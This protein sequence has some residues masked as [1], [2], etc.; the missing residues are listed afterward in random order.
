MEVEAV[1]WWGT[2]ARTAPGRGRLAGR[3]K[4][5]F[6]VASM[7]HGWSWLAGAPGLVLDRSWLGF[8]LQVCNCIALHAI[9]EAFIGD[10]RH[11]WAAGSIDL[12]C[13][14]G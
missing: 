7:A 14:D 9:V 10:L 2:P 13:T 12:Y 6:D 4:F 1:V 11:A 8:P 3:S 5:E